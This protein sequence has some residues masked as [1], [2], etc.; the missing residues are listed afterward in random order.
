V[1]SSE[2]LSPSQIFLEAFRRHS[3]GLCVVT[4]LKADGSPTGF[5]ATSV[6]SLS[7]SPPLASFNMSQTASSWSALKKD[8][9]VAL[10]FLGAESLE[11]AGIMAGEASERFVGDHWSSGPHGLPILKGVSA[12]VEG[13][14]VERV[15]VEFAGM[16]AI[17]ITGGEL[18]PEQSPLAYH[19]KAY[20]TT[21]AL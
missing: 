18:G 10:H 11:L 12:W 14:V 20:S 6:A 5:T 15:E 17:R 1:N 19:Q 16:I 21:A 9:K 2:P 4:A 3:A 7:A 8:A 13:H